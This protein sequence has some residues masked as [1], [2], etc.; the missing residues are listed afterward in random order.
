MPDLV[1]VAVLK[2]YL[3][4][5]TDGDDTLLGTLLDHAEGLFESETG[6]KDTPFTAA[7]TARSEVKD[8]TGSAELYLDYPISTV[9]SISLGFDSTDFD[10]TLTPSDADEVVWG[11][12]SRRIMRVDGGIFGR[13]AQP[14]Y[15]TIV[16]DAQADLPEEAQLAIKRVTAQVYRQRGSEDADREQIGSYIRDLSNLVDADPLW[17][18]AV[19]ANRRRVLA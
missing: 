1:S 9:T 8:G 18:R 11:A 2:T 19:E 6:R 7:D 15:L 16:Y 10:E 14:R 5:T 3:E 17:R 12:G 4:I 13:V